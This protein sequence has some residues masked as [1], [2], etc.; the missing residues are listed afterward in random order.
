MGL[1]CIELHNLFWFIFYNFI[2]VLWSIFGK[3]TQLTRVIFF[4]LFFNWFISQIHHL[5]LSL[6]WIRI[7][8]FSSLYGV[9]KVSWPECRALW[10]NWVGLGFFLSFLI[11]YFLFNFI[12]QHLVDWELDFIIFIY[13]LSIKLS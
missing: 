6:L 8:I 9:I 12:L 4:A 1:M 11:E 3:L 10:G 2:I 7:H 5:V 13:F